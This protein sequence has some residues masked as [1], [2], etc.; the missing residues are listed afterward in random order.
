MY[1]AVEEEFQV[2]CQPLPHTMVLQDQLDCTSRSGGGGTLGEFKEEPKADLVSAAPPTDDEC[3]TVMEDE[4][5]WIQ[6]PSSSHQV[7]VA[8]VEEIKAELLHPNTPTAARIKEE[9]T[10]AGLN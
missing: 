8:A 2:I 1:G 7:A 5:E 6:V 3:Y 4:L 10:E 9:F